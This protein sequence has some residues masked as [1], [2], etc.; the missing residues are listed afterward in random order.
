LDPVTFPAIAMPRLVGLINKELHHG[1]RRVGSGVEMKNAGQEI[2][3]A[4]QFP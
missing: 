4:R 1:R 2:A 3:P